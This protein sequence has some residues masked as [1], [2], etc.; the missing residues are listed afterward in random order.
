MTKC[1]FP[2]AVTRSYTENDKQDLLAGLRPITTRSSIL[3][4][5]GRWRYFVVIR[6]E[7][8]WAD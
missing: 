7:N 1:N 5:G 2:L 3:R 6:R 4:H 8:C